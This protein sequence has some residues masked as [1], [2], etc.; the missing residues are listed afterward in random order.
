[1]DEA[2]ED[3]MERSCEL[4]RWVNWGKRG[5]TGNRT[6]LAL[7]VDKNDSVNVCQNLQ[8]PEPVDILRSTNGYGRNWVGRSG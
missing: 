3:W 6:A 1:M 5:V 7:S 2:L 8:T 4:K